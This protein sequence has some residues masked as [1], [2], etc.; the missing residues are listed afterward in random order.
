[1]D[2]N[3]MHAPFN[4]MKCNE[5]ELNRKKKGGWGGYNVRVGSP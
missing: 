4:K 5:I 3:K 2:L 1:M